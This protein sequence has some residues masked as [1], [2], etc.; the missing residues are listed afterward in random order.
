VHLGSDRSADDC[1]AEGQALADGLTAWWRQTIRAEHRI[2]SHLDMEF[3]TLYRRFFLPTRRGSDEGSAKRYAGLV[4]TADGPALRVK[5][6]EAVRTDWTPLARRV[7]REL[8]MRV[9]ARQPYE[10]YLKQVRTQLVGGDLDDELVYTKRLR[11]PVDAYEGRL[12]V[13]V[14][15]A[16]MLDKPVRRVSYVIT[17]KGPEPV[18]AQRTALDY[19]HY[20][21]RQLAPACD[22]VLAMLGKSFER[23]TGNQLG[24]F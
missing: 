1:L 23:L 12:P 17:S 13:H 14:Q 9:L 6:L 15:A 19:D 4:D 7:Q 3:E 22:G 10:A 20:L 16:R 21:H 2:D 24:L 18:T 5:G 8:L 11:R